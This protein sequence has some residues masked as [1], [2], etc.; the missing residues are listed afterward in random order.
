MKVLLFLGMFLL[1][2]KTHATYVGGNP[3]S[4]IDPTGLYTE[5]TVWQPVGYG[6]SSFG[7]VSIDVNNTTYTF[8]PSGMAT[9]PTTDYISRNVSFRSGIGLVLS[10]T[11]LQEAKL[12]EYLKGYKGSYNLVSNSCVDPVQK[13]LAQ[14]GVPLGT[15]YFPVSLGNSILSSLFL[16]GVSNHDQVKG[17]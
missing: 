9:F 14:V 3:L 4:Y 5:V 8:G 12:V 6:S 7:H 11:K 13:G 15:S 2:S 10:L 17:K 16:G 1:F